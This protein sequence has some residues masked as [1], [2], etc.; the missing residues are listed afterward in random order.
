MMSLSD[1]QRLLAELQQKADSEVAQHSQR[2]FKTGEGEYGEGDIFLG[3]RVPELRK[4]SRR[5]KKL[6]LEA[7]SDLLHSP[8]HETRLIAL[9]ILVMQFEKAD[10]AEQKAIYELYLSLTDRVNNWDLVDSSAHKIVGPYLYDKDRSVLLEL[11]RSPSLWERR[12]ATIATFYYIPKNEFEE[13]FAIAEI[14]LKDSH[15][16]IQKA[17]GWMLREIGNR[18]KE[19]ETAFLDKHY[20]N[21]PRTMLRYAIEKYTKEERQAYLQGTR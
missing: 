19:I 14:L 15:D 17:V 21:M 20:R 5:F 6:S 11:A 2:Y 7:C 1:Y 4:L 12:I 18:D 9:Y 3:I 10:A 13:A 8:H 16:L